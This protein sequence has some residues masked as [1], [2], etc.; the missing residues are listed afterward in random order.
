MINK[1]NI[2]TAAVAGLAGGSLIATSIYNSI[3]SAIIGS[4]IGAFITGYS[5]YKHQTLKQ[6]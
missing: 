4:L 3:L 2:A 1:H 6:N 5:E